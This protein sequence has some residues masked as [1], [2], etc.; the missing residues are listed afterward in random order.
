MA[1]NLSAI[2]AAIRQMLRD[3]FTAG[4]DLKWED[5]EL[6]LHISE[7]LLELSDKSPYKVVEVLTTIENSRILDISSIEDLVRIEKL[8]YPIGSEPRDYRNLIELDAET[9]EIDTTITPDAGDSGTLTGTVT[10]T[11]G[12]AA[13]TGSGTAFTSEL[14]VNYLIKKSSGTRWYRVYSIESDTA[15][16][17]AE[18]VRSADNGAD[19]ENLTEY[20]YEAVYLYCEKYHSL[21]ESSSTL[22]PLE[23]NTLILGVCAK[24]AIAKAQEHIDK[25]NVGGGTTP[26]QLQA[27][28]ISKLALYQSRLRGL[29]PPRSK[30]TYPKS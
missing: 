29:T 30:R 13:I 1:R 27:W 5:D 10:F 12:S 25:V 7:C 21:T 17:L 4:T 3:E 11:S 26:S 19:T 24:A 2:R 28:G 14:K 23:E 16:T 6:D 8:E 20:C 22:K 9:I 18:P 15:L